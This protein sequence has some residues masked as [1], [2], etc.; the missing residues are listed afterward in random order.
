MAEH[1]LI[2]ADET[3]AALFTPLQMGSVTL[4]NRIGM[5][6]MCQYS[7]IDGVAQEWH[8]AH[9]GARAAGGLGLIVMEATGVEP[10]GRITP[11]CLGLWND[12][13]RDALKPIVA[14][15]KGQ[16][17][18]MGIQLAHAG[19][20]ASCALPWQGG[21]QLAAAQGGWQTLAPS[22][23]AFRDGDMLPQAMTADD[24]ARL[25]DAF[26]AAARRAADAGFD[27]VELHG[28]H[29][30]LLHSFLS[31]LTNRREDGYGGDL[32]GRSRLLREVAAA[33]RAALPAH[34]A[35]ITRLSCS[36]WQAGGLTPADCAIVARDLKKLGVEL[37]DCSSG[38]LTHDAKIVVGPGYQVPFAEEV[39]RDGDIM[40]GAVGMIT[41]ARQA[42]EIVQKGQADMVFLARVLLRDPY[43]ALKAAALAG[44]D[45]PVAQQYLR[46]IDRAGLL[47]L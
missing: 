32:S 1:A 15:A 43:W 41:G 5:S 30:Y 9:I 26:V 42:G 8:H 20:K 10:A 11:G 29:G 34:M 28:A 39:R 23:L 19:R 3:V 21:R 16:G 27:V 36:D 40:T 7:A 2:P 14:F 18:A 13:Q 17:T 47:A 31:P 24:I 37:I 45:L 4:R 25:V 6:P 35:L 12:A 44:A 46:G 38:G 22:A 33:V